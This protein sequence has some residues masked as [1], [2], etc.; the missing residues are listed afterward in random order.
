VDTLL[1]RAAVSCPRGIGVLGEDRLRLPVCGA[2]H[3][4]GRAVTSITSAYTS[5]PAIRV[6][7][8]ASG[9]SFGGPLAES[10]LGSSAFYAQKA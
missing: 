3:S 6:C 10:F 2:C 4:F 9:I 8:I 5:T 7:G 1:A